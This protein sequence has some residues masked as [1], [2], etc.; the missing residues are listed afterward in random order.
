MRTGWVAAWVLVVT[1]SVATGQ[2]VPREQWSFEAQS[3]LYAAPL[4]ADMAPAP[5]LE[6]VVSD[7][8]ARRLLCI[9]ATG[10]QLWEYAGGWT[11]RL[12]SRAALSFAARPGAGTLAVGNPDGLLCCVDA[13]TG[14]ELWKRHVGRIVWGA[15]L[16]ADLD[17]DGRDELVA[18]TEDAGLVALDADGAP[19]WQTAHRADGAPLSIAGPPAAADID[20]DGA[21]A[22]FALDTWGPVCVS[23]DGRIL[24]QT[25]TG[26]RFV[27]APV[28]ADADGDGVPELYAISADGPAL[29][30]FNARDGSARWRFPLLGPA[31]G[32]S[33]AGL[34]VGEVLGRGREEIVAAD[35][36]GNVYCVTPDGDL[37][38][39]FATTLRIHAAVTL[40]DVD[41]D[42]A[43]D[44][45][46]ASGDRCLY[47]LDHHGRVKWQ[48][49]TGLRLIAPATLADVTGDGFAQI[50]VGGSDRRLRCLTMDAPAHGSPGPWPSQRFDPAQTGSS[51]GKRPP[52]AALRAQG[53][54][55]LLRDG[56]FEHAGHPEPPEAYPADSRLHAWR[57]GLPRGWRLEAGAPGAA[58]ID[59]ETAHTGE[60]ALLLNDGTLASEPIPLEWGTRAVS[61]RIQVRA[62]VD[63]EVYLRWE[64]PDGPLGS[65]ALEPPAGGAAERETWRQFEAVEAAVPVNARRVTLV[66]RA[67]GDAAWF[68]DAQVTGHWDRPRM[69]RA[70]VNQVGYDAGAPKRFTACANFVPESA[71]FEL[72]D[73]TGALVFSGPLEHEGRV[74]GA[75]GNV[76][77]YEYFRGDFSAFDAPGA[78][79]LRV[80]ADGVLHESWPFAIGHDLLWD[81]TAAPAYAFFYYQRCG[82][83]VPG[84]HEACHLDD[85]V[86]PDGT[87]QFDLA[88]GW[89]DAGDYN[90]YHNA[91]YVFGLATA[92]LE[93]QARFDAEPPAGGLPGFRDEILWG[94]D[95]VRRM[96]APDGSARG[97]LTSG[98]G[99]WGPPELETDNLPGTGDERPVTR[100]DGDDSTL[101]TAAAARTARF[102][103]DKRPHIEAAERGLAWALAGGRRGVAQFCAAL[104]LYAATGD[105][106]HAVTAQELF[107]G[108]SIECVEAIELYDAL[109]GEDHRDALRALLAARAD[110][111]I[112]LARNPFGVYTFGPKDTP[113]FFGTT[114]HD[115][116]WH[117]GTS[118]HLLGAARIAA[119]AYRYTK[120]P[121]H[122]A[123]AYDQINWILGNNPFG[124]C[125]MEAVGSRH[126]PSYHHRY[127]FS[128]VPRGAVPGGVVNGI[129]W[130]A[131]GDDR[132]HF[133]MSGRDIP[134]FQPNEVWLPHNTAYLNALTALQ[135]ARDAE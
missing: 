49:A 6:T 70:L 108:A 59:R 66:C 85:A 56:G 110:E 31:D 135:S 95:H 80:Y 24:W 114:A 98:Y 48:Y 69:A 21:A 35:S 81:R 43:T 121:R 37:A 30:R 82:M 133:D 10:R 87:Q 90:K 105:D 127:T 14:A 92:Y 71:A 116:G 22:V 118:S 44:V 23:G 12:A 38:W 8:E 107:P 39:T 122:L 91:P 25:Y 83:A 101:H 58:R 120:D 126:A 13:A 16:W 112:A 53:A 84:F 46:V 33:G 74:R 125:L 79:R 106:R 52:H 113:N 117:V 75:F 54:D 65:V 36:W 97:H 77:G 96:F 88:G 93:Q 123:F 119:T 99:F 134:D 11:R 86:G 100:L 7:S 128:G 3:N 130:R 47:C 40:G 64:G 19:R 129:T 1:A 89:H 76:W 20:G 67:G 111:M 62:G 131:P 41:G 26:D 15:A 68:D 132:P 103:P 18:G 45:L 73:D 124:V 34:A 51:F 55:A 5:G 27:G 109:F 2:A 63:P 72:V 60:A 29:H 61:A 115:T 57:S 17:G 4:T 50:L 9:D 32:Y 78:Y 102:A 94:A 42:G 104:D 28:V